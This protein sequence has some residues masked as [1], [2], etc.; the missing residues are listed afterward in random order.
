MNYSTG[1]GWLLR[2]DGVLPM[3]EGWR[4]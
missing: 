3:P 2:L 4:D 1:V